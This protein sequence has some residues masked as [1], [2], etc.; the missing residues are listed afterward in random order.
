MQ[1]YKQLKLSKEKLDQIHGLLSSSQGAGAGSGGSDVDF[2]VTYD[3]EDQEVQRTLSSAAASPGPTATRRQHVLSC[4]QLT[5]L[6]NDQ[7]FP[8]LGSAPSTEN[9]T[10]LPSLVTSPKQSRSKNHLATSQMILRKL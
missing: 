6:N 3:R 5:G 10:K 1:S 2:E 7:N 9:F 8:M 4:A